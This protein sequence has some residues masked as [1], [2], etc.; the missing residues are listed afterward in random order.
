MQNGMGE[1]DIFCE[2]CQLVQ[3]QLSICCV[4]LSSA[5]TIP[6]IAM[7]EDPPPGHSCMA[8]GYKTACRLAV[9]IFYE[10]MSLCYHKNGEWGMGNVY[11]LSLAV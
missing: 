9:I 1:P 4:K 6:I 5:V 11:S 10:R 2:V 3:Y 8:R 7:I